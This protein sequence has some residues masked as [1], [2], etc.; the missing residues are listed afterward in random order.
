MVNQPEDDKRITV[1]FVV[2]RDQAEFVR[3]L[4]KKHRSS[5]SY[6]MRQAIDLL[7]KQ[8]QSNQPEPV[9]A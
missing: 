1:S 8:E 9:A 6:V 5:R 3:A 4:A 2:D 7:Q